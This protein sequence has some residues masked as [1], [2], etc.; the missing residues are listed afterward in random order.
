MPPRTSFEVETMFEVIHF[1]TPIRF[2]T[3]TTIT[4]QVIMLSAFFGKQAEN[5]GLVRADSRKQELR[6]KT[7]EGIQ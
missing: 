7:V 3:V 2:D 4:H 6:V 1:P 5:C